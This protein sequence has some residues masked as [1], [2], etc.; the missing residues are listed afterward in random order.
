MVKGATTSI[1]NDSIHLASSLPVG[2]VLLHVTYS[3]NKF[4]LSPSSVPD[5]VLG[6]LGRDREQTKSL[7]FWSF[8]FNLGDFRQQTGA[9]LG[10]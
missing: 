10:C 6:C 8:C 2:E 3:L 1:S 4:I 7:L 5:V 9:F